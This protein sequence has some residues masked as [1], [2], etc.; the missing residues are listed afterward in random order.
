M[1]HIRPKGKPKAC[2]L[3]TSWSKT[4]VDFKRRKAKDPCYVAWP[5]RARRAREN[6]C[7]WVPSHKPKGVFLLALFT[8]Q[9]DS[10]LLQPRVPRLPL[11]FQSQCHILSPFNFPS[12]N[13]TFKFKYNHVHIISYHQITYPTLFVVKY[14]EFRLQT[15]GV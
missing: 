9:S 13:F 5:L 10:F 8:S 7:R 12:L 6:S 1:G 11:P 14:L 4:L 3:W 2:F 15:G